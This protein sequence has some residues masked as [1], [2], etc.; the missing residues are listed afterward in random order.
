MN[1]INKVILASIL[2]SLAGHG[3]EI[4]FPETSASSNGI[5]IITA[6]K[7]K[8]A[9]TPFAKWKTATGRPTKIITISSIQKNYNGADVQDKMR[10]CILKHGD[11][12]KTRW[13]ILGGDSSPHLPLVPDR[14]SKHLV[15]GSIAYDDIPSDSYYV[16]AK[17]WDANKDGIYGDW[18]KDRDELEYTNDKIFLG[19]V[20]VRVTEDVKAYTDK[21]I[22]YESSYPADS[23]AKSLVYTGT[24]EASC[25]KLLTSW[26]VIKENWEGEGVH[27]FSHVTPWDN[28]KGGDYALSTANLIAKVNEKAYS[29]FHIHGHGYLPLWFLED[30][31]TLTVSSVREMTNKNAYL[32]LTTVSCFTGQFDNDLDPSITES[33]LRQPEAGAVIVIAPAREG[34]PIFHDPQTDMKKMVTEGKMDG[35]TTLMTSFWKHGLKKAISAGEAFHLAKKDMASDAA[36]N[37]GYHWCLSELNFLG[38]PSIDLRPAPPHTPELKFKKEGG[39]ITVSSDLQTD[40]ILTLWQ[41]GVFYKRYP[42]TG[43]DEVVITLPKGFNHQADYSLSIAGKGINAVLKQ[44]TDLLKFQ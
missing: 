2:S 39:T 26:D 35:T 12:N 10:Q 19:R 3:S 16:S 42:I 29:K 40:A 37:S 14:D 34:V 11:A 21:V 9:W 24:V 13:V 28:K 20:P 15:Y 17:S 8:D 38:D 25:P 23:F 5:L 32:C 44:S 6:E 30:D 27:F 18:K 36:I 41:Q 43:S 22:A 33:M 7:L 31:T 4:T 1:F